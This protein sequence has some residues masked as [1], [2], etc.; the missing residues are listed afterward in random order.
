MTITNEQTSEA[1]KVDS[2]YKKIYRSI[3]D[4]CK[5]LDEIYKSPNAFLK[6]FQSE[7]TMLR[8]KVKVYCETLMFRK[9]MEYAKK[10]NTPLTP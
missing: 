5:K 9:P 10:V 1:G 2:K 7:T 6:L 4:K 8:E 3:I